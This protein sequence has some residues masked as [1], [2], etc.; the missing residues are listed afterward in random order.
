MT[1]GIGPIAQMFAE[2]H[3]FA[4]LRAEIIKSNPELRERELIKLQ[5]LA[6]AIGTALGARGVRQVAEHIGHAPRDTSGMSDVSR[7]ADASA[8]SKS[9]TYS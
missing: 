7:S 6:G 8:L 4:R 1:E 3:V 2:R 9:R 5:T